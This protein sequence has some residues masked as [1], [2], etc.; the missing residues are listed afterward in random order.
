MTYKSFCDKCGSTPANNTFLFPG[1]RR[2][3][4]GDKDLCDIC[5]DTLI[6]HLQTFFPKEDKP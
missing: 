3:L 2:G 4:P 1:T 6:T 5:Y